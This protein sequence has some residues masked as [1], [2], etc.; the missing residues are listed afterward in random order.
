M[1]VNDVN[2]M[3]SDIFINNF[4]NVFENTHTIAVITEKMRPFENKNHLIKTFLNEFDKLTVNN[5]KKIIKNHPDLGNKFKINNDL[6]EMSINEQKNVGLENCTEEEFF[7]FKK[8]NNE[9]KSKFD[10]PFIFAVK[11][12]NKSIIIEEFKKRL[13][14]DNIEKEVEESIKQVKQIANFRLNEIVDE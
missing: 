13:Q 9:F 7:L 1:K 5:K 4:K 14:N 11:G 8:L 12:K 3:S 10:I 6:T 2:V